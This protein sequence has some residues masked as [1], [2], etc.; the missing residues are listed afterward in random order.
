MAVRKRNKTWWYDFTIKGKRHR[1]PLPTARTKRDA[2]EKA[3]RVKISII[4]GS[5][6]KPVP[7]TFGQFVDEI[8]W[9]WALANYTD[10]KNSHLTHTT[11]AKN[12][13][14]NKALT[15]ISVLDIERFK[16]ERMALKTRFNADRKPATVNRDLQQLAAILEMARVNGYIVKNPAREVKHLRHENQ[17]TRY[18]TYD[19]EAQV[20]E[21][22]K[23]YY[24][25]FKP[26][27]LFALNTGMR[28]GEIVKLDWADVDFLRGVIYVKQTKT[29]KPRSIPM[30]ETV[31]VLLEGLGAKQGGKVFCQAKQTISDAW[32]WIK[33]KLE[34][35]DITFHDLR[36]TF[37]TRL[38]D[39]GVDPFTIAEILGHSDLKMT[40]RYTHS[41]EVNKR[42]AVESLVTNQSQGAKRAST[43]KAV[44]SIK[45]T[46]TGTDN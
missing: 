28:R 2:E 14:E 41:L 30:N 27:F 16:R 18:L 6:N 4:D 29:A 43:G 5:F 19:E 44:R 38:A 15:E 31:T 42:R 34:L 17:R 24:K 10:P 8:F 25:S 23:I 37:A 21:L 3:D 26:V 33:A 35:S 45:R 7:K 46:F 13:F 11:V 12:Y 39:A 36:H 9:P 22:F 1:G 40:K 20:M 32:K